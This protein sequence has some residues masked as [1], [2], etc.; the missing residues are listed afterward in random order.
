MQLPKKGMVTCQSLEG[1]LVTRHPD[2]TVPEWHTV[3]MASFDTYACSVCSKSFGESHHRCSQHVNAWR[4]PCRLKGAFV[5]R[6]PVIVGRNDR[7]AGGRQQNGDDIDSEAD[8]NLLEVRA[9][10]VSNLP[11][12][13]D[14]AGGGGEL[15]SGYISIDILVLTK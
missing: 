5:K 3:V 12:D 1:Q 9:G 11:V 4:G 2:S 8:A 13:S 6:V 7:N 10:S 15:D 14:D